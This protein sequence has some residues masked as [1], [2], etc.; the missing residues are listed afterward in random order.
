MKVFLFI[1]VLLFSTV[2]S[3]EELHGARNLNLGYDFHQGYLFFFL[4]LKV[5]KFQL[6]KQNHQFMNMITLLQ[7]FIHHLADQI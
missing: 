4:N 2:Y 5:D 3:Q 7:D 1:V 6:K